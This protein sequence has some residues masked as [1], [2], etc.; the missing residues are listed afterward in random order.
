MKTV[1]KAFAIALLVL[2]L[3]IWLIQMG[4]RNLMSF[5]NFTKFTDMVDTKL[6]MQMFQFDEV[7]NA[8]RFLASVSGFA[9]FFEAFVLIFGILAAIF[10]IRNSTRKKIT[11][12]PGCAFL[13]VSIFDLFCVIVSGYINNIEIIETVTDLLR[14]QNVDISTIYPVINPLGTTINS[15]L[16]FILATGFITC[17][18]L[19]TLNSKK[20]PE[21][22]SETPL[23]PKLKKARVFY[24][25]SAISIVA[26][27]LVASFVSA[28]FNVAT[29]SW[30]FR[31]FWQGYILF[32]IAAIVC[33][34]IGNSM[35]PIKKVKKEKTA[36]VQVSIQQTSSADELKKYKELLD[37]GIITQE[38]FDAKKKQLLGL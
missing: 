16:L 24:W 19:D 1:R 35:N 17:G 21:G 13:L 37:Q 33:Y 25:I 29:I 26:L 27:L 28:S 36:P 32:I 4:T 20:N 23:D 12:I 31:Y 2:T 22:A 5:E 6:D 38:E 34:I 9:K 30:I 7:Y 14:Y 8:G 10:I 11:L 3:P 18:I 15:A